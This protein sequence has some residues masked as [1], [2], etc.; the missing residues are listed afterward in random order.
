MQRIPVESSD[1]VSI[2]YDS[3]EHVLEIEFGG[4][5]IYRYFEVPEDVYRLFLRADSY[6]GY[7]N[8]HINKY[9]KYRRVDEAA[10]GEKFEGV[11]FV[12][13]NERKLRDLQ[14]ACTEFDIP[15][16]Q[17]SLPIDEIQSDDFEKIIRH[18]ARQAYM[19]AGK[20]VV[21]NDSFWNIPALKGFPGAY[22]KEV[23]HW[24]SPDD[25]LALM[26][27]KS[28]RSI[29]CTDTLMYFDGKRSK[30]FSKVHWGTIT[31]TPRGDGLAIERVIVM[32]GQ[33]ETVAEANNRTDE[34][35]VDIKQTVWYEFAKWFATQRKLR[36]FGRRT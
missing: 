35:V 14:A 6:G 32:Q 19:S 11:V 18:K 36:S 4:H 8:A 21:V 7:F 22:M 13:G 3:R 15:V 12:S 23:T 16:E 28:D 10:P 17:L 9:Y 31:D 20:P 2:G 5:R 33:H 26:A 27:T 30:L 1:I 24:F 34:P 25:F 29:S